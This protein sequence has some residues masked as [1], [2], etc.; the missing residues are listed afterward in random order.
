M[1]FTRLSD[2]GPYHNVVLEARLSFTHATSGIDFSLC[3]RGNKELEA[4]VRAVDAVVVSPGAQTKVRA[5]KVYA[6]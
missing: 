3:R 1:P 6:A 5:T 2:T 4:E